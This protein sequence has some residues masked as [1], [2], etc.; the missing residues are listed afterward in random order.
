MPLGAITPSRTTQTHNALG[1]EP[2]I[3][4]NRPMSSSQVSHASPAA[5]SLGAADEDSFDAFAAPAT[6]GGNTLTTGRRASDFL[7]WPAEFSLDSKQGHS[8]QLIGLSNESD[9]YLL[10]HY[11]YGIHDTYSM[12]RL[13][14]RS[15]MQDRSMKLPG[16]DNQHGPNS[17]PMGEVP[18]QFVMI[19]EQILKDEL[20]AAEGVLLGSS[21]EQDDLELLSKL[22]SSDLGPRLLKL[23]VVLSRLTKHV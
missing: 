14:F 23:Y 17:M 21:T 7:D 16:Y 12:F 8:S 20:Q 1:P 22:V 15:V 10:R 18:I 4:A 5:T 13:H 11:M 2:M 9:P 19:D 6:N 3:S